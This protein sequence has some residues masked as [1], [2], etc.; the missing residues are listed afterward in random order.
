MIVTPTTRRPSATATIAGTKSLR[1]ATVTR[2]SLRDVLLGVAGTQYPVIAQGHVVGWRWKAT[3]A[4]CASGRRLKYETL[5]PPPYFP[6]YNL[7][8]VQQG[9]L[10]YLLAGEP[11]VWVATQAGLIAVCFLMGE[12]CVPAR[13]VRLLAERRPAVVRIVYDLDTA[14]TRGADR[15]CHALRAAGLQAEI[16][17]LPAWVGHKG[18]VADA[19][20]GLRSDDAALRL[21]LDALPRRE[22]ASPPIRPAATPGT[23]HT[24]SAGGDVF[25]RVRA[26]ADIVALARRLTTLHPNHDESRYTGL[27]PFHDDHHPSFVVWSATEDKPGRF[28]C[29]PC[30]LG[31]DAIELCRLALERG[32][33]Q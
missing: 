5:G 1:P 16:L 8:D 22:P 18:D 19:Y 20:H 11:D 27:C 2:F 6:V 17:T 23:R 28:C 30:G 31:G 4:Y 10:V 33:L 13:G 12:A 21:L 32:L 3:P 25:A 14:G 24:H 29:H 15:A 9:Q 7:D 26:Q